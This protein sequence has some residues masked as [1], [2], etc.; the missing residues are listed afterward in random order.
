MI[1][2]GA[3]AAAQPTE[4]A[5]LPAELAAVARPAAPAPLRRKRVSWDPDRAVS[6][7]PSVQRLHKR[8][9]QLSAETVNAAHKAAWASSSSSDGGGGGAAEG[10]EDEQHD[11]DVEFD[12]DAVVLLVLPPVGAAAAAAAAAAAPPVA[13]QQQQQQQQHRSPLLELPTVVLSEVLARCGTRQAALAS[14]TCRAWSA[15]FRSP[16][17]WRELDLVQLFG[18]QRRWLGESLLLADDDDSGTELAELPSALRSFSAFMLADGGRR[19]SQLTSLRVRASQNDRWTASP[20]LCEVPSAVLLR[21][22]SCAKLV[23]SVHISGRVSTPAHR[24]E[25]SS[26]DY[27]LG[28]QGSSQLG[29]LL[30]LRACSVAVGVQDQTWLQVFGGL[31]GVCELELRLRFDLARE[32]W[33]GSAGGTKW[34][35]SMGTRHLAVQLNCMPQLQQ[36]K[37]SCINS[38]RSTGLPTERRETVGLAL[39]G[40]VLPGLKKLEITASKPGLQV[41]R[42]GSCS[43]PA[44][45]EVDIRWLSAD[46]ADIA[47]LGNV[48]AA[49][50]PAQCPA[51]RRLTIRIETSVLETANWR[52]GRNDHKLIPE[53]E[54]WL[55]KAAQ[56]NGEKFLAA[57]SGERSDS[58]RA[59]RMSIAADFPESAT[60]AAH[61][62]ST[63]VWWAL[64]F[65]VDQEDTFV[66]CEP[67]SR[68][69]L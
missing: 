56:D 34:D 59:V 5:A 9:R 31:G 20:A 64:E 47:E 35:A 13:Q 24:V 15:A 36:L 23:E 61:Q 69:D 60:W 18:C 46:A 16:A 22:I 39:S 62:V 12:D 52:L 27:R 1:G 26:E 3:A 8:A 44:L 66:P 41:C 63:Q 4:L 10:G 6:P 42:L 38:A 57:V 28:G 67:A 32:W 30:Q 14:R 58:W 55:A 50:G 2:G 7:V 68:S 53:L 25:A 11:S 33:D 43:L 48:C 17:A 19:L 37:L 40:L 45:V 21:M 65:T 49:F 51:L 29:S 54:G